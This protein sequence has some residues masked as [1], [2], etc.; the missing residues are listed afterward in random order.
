MKNKNSVSFF[1]I[2]LLLLFFVLGI[3]EAYGAG[4]GHGGIDLRRIFFQSFNLLL[5]GGGIVYIV[6]P[7]LVTF[8]KEQ[9]EAYLKAYHSTKEDKQKALHKL[10]Q[11][12]AKLSQL[13]KDFEKELE[14]AKI[15]SQEHYNKLLKEAD[16]NIQHMEKGLK[17]NMQRE[18]HLAYNQLKSKLIEEISKQSQKQIPEALNAK[19]QEKIEDRFIHH[20]DTVSL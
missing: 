17:Q 20:V 12:Q 10:Q 9:K 19:T 2:A 18:L 8:F 15:A 5:I 16:E 4:Q 1:F 13:E 11:T 6:G 14:K 3:S 7:S